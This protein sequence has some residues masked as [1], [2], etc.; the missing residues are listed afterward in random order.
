MRAAAVLDAIR[1][2][3]RPVFDAAAPAS[4]AR[5]AAACWGHR[6]RRPNFE[7]LAATVFR[8]DALSREWAVADAARDRLSETQKRALSDACR[9]AAGAEKLRGLQVYRRRRPPSFIGGRRSRGATQEADADRRAAVARAAAGDLGALVGWTA[10]VGA[11]ADAS[12]GL[13]VGVVKRRLLVRYGDGREALLK[14]LLK[15]PSARPRLRLRD[16]EA[17]VPIALLERAGL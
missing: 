3:A 4:L 15:P 12:P 14:P 5:T 2:G 16:R 1:A 11:A 9:A 6:S 8:G 7:E 10:R 13:V 17:E